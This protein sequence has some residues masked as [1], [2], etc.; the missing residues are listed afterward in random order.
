MA[1]TYGEIAANL[2]ANGYEPIP[3]TP[4]SKAIKIP[5]WSKI[6]ISDAQVARWRQ[7]F[8]SHG[9]GIRTKHTPAIDIDVLDER[10]ALLIEKVLLK[11]LGQDTPVRIGRAPKRLVLCRT[12][13]PFPKIKREFVAPDGRTHAV[14]I[15]GD[16][17]QFVAYGIHPDT[18]KPY[19]WGLDDPMSCPAENLPT[20]THA[21]GVKILDRL[22]ALLA[23]KLNWSQKK[24]QPKERAQKTSSDPLENFKAKL[25]ISDLE[26]DEVLSNIPNTANTHYD[27]WATVGMALW[28]QYDGSDE[29]YA[30]WVAW[31]EQGPKHDENEMPMKWDSFQPD[32]HSAPV[33]FASVIKMSQDF[34][35][36]AAVERNN[37]I[38]QQIVN[39]KNEVELQ[40]I[41]KELRKLDLSDQR[42]DDFVDKLSK[43]YKEIGLAVTKTSLKKQL[44][45]KKQ[46]EAMEGKSTISIEASLATQVLNDYFHSGEHLV[47]MGGECW[48]YDGGV[49]RI[50]DGNYIR[51]KVLNLLQGMHSKDDPVYKRLVAATADREDRLSA[52]VS[53]VTDITKTMRTKDS[54]IDPLNLRGDNTK[55]VVNCKN[56]ELWLSDDGEIEEKEHWA[57]NYLTSQLAC[58]Y[59]PM[60]ECPMF[61]DAL[62]T[63]F[64]RCDDPG[65]VIRHWCEVMGVLLQPLRTQAFWVLMKGPGGN[66]KSLLL[67]I[68]SKLLGRSCYS[69]SLNEIS[70]RNGVNAHF[71]AGLV[72]K[73][74][75][76]D[77]DMK[78]GTVLPDDWMKKLSEPKVLTA[79]PKFGT[80]FEFTC[81]ATAV[82]LTNRWPS[83]S[84]ISVGMRRR[85]QIF[86]TDN[87]I[88]EHMQ[89]PRLAEKIINNELPGVLNLLLN[90][91]IRVLQR[92]GHF[93]VPSDCK[94]S[95]ET[96]LAA[97]NPTA[98]FIAQCVEINP[99]A[100]TKGDTLFDAY[101]RW[102]FEC[103]DNIKPLGRNS[104][105]E[106]L[107]SEGFR[108]PR[109]KSGMMFEGVA[110]RHNWEKDMNDPFP[111]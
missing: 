83:S 106:V 103:D 65:E 94:R 74:M 11:M 16:G 77:D 15:L 50:T 30:R 101:R 96:W 8:P 110:L 31:S 102:A 14:E 85:A 92:G 45:A 88:P 26:I 60:A 47:Y 34:K 81:R 2:A 58:D 38:A 44:S 4:N 1:E 95:L 54:Q 35:A 29:G 39:T 90:G 51:F 70:G 43:Q 111:S 32:N 66:G 76:L 105:Y 33:T 3:I 107:R 69:G 97:S 52:L 63:I 13:E 24:N 49:W 23:E 17:Q 27:D 19:L 86:E 108:E 48:L 57:E 73:Y 71:T 84:D 64:S 9:V 67:S 93:N 20:L 6:D 87:C 12:D 68:I 62:E 28:H 89:D 56:C 7:D 78:A 82:A 25:N 21:M 75:F 36:E 79:N 61:V 18:K 41:I 42:K 91:L 53:S 5:N 98:R 59:D 72:G 80:P 99:L 40:R 37:E 22:A 109:G 104:F 46:V 55:P 100:R 10:A